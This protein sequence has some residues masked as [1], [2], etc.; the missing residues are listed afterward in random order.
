[1]MVISIMERIFRRKA[2]EIHQFQRF[3]A[4]S[5]M[6]E[7]LIGSPV[8]LADVRHYLPW[9]LGSLNCLLAAGPILRRPRR[10]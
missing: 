4:A 8:R 5:K 3:S 2:W 6:I 7:G 10:P 9:A 1:M